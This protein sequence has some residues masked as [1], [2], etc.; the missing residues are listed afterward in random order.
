MFLITQKSISTTQM[1]YRDAEKITKLWK[2]GRKIQLDEFV[3]ACKHPK[4]YIDFLKS[5][6]TYYK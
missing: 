4:D 6:I 5:L 3:H 2:K 1:N